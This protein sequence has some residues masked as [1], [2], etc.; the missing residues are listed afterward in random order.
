MMAQPKRN[1]TSFGLGGTRSNAATS[2]AAASW[3]GGDARG[4][5][6]GIPCPQTH[7]PFGLDPQTVSVDL[8]L[9]ARRATLG[10]GRR[11]PGVG[12]AVGDAFHGAVVDEARVPRARGVGE[13]GYLV[14]GWWLVVG[15]W[16]LVIGGWWLV[17][18][19]W[20]LVAGGWWLVV[21]GW[22]LVT[23]NDIQLMTCDL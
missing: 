23:T 6:E 2:M 22:W 15:G 16:W 10:R 17:V 1:G 7:A 20:W 21:G 11:P 13:E 19:G 8:G 4:M 18:G 14:G 3:G 12:G 5:G 9:D